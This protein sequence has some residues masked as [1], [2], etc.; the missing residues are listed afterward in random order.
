MLPE[1][2]DIYIFSIR[3]GEVLGLSPNI[4][5]YRY[6]PGQF[7]DAHCKLLHRPPLLLWHSPAFCLLSGQD[8]FI[9]PRDIFHHQPPSATVIFHA[10]SPNP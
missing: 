6:S 2:A 10:L 3:G 9:L 5:I 4:R 7:F 1:V 8:H